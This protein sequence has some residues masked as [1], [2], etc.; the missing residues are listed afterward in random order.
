[1]GEVP[2]PCGRGQAYDACCGR[3]HRGEEATTAEDLMR[4]RYTAFVKRDAAYLF[5]TLH[6]AHEDKRRG[7]AAFFSDMKRYF[8]ERTVYRKLE[9]LDSAGPDA[10]G[11]SKVLFLAQLARRGKDVSFAELS[12]F[13]HDGTGLRYLSGTTMAPSALG[14]KRERAQIAI[15]EAE[16]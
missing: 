14:P 11:I 16:L 8:A 7:E 1:M 13:A 9:I 4:S 15:L 2:C 6:A 3:F 12:L 10:Q 5:R